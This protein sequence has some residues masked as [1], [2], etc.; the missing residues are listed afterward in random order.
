MHCE[1]QL[2]DEMGE[3]FLSAES[4]GIKGEVFGLAELMVY[5]ALEHSSAIT[6]VEL[7]RRLCSQTFKAHLQAFGLYLDPAQVEGLVNDFPTSTLV[8]QELKG[9]KYYF[10]MSRCQALRHWMEK[11]PEEYKSLQAQ[12]HY[13]WFWNLFTCIRNIDVKPSNVNQLSI[14][15]QQNLKSAAWHAMQIGTLPGSAREVL[16]Q[17][18]GLTDEQRRQRTYE[19]IASFLTAAAIYR[20][21]GNLKEGY[22]LIL[23]AVD[24]L[25]DA[26]DPWREEWLECMADQS[27][28][29]YWLSG[30]TGVREQQG[31]LIA[32]FP[33]LTSKP[34]WQIHQRFEEMLHGHE[35]LS[36][37]P[38]DPCLYGPYLCN[39]HRLTETLWDIRQR[40]GVIA[41]AL[42]DNAVHIHEAVV[43]LGASAFLN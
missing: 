30:D 38:A 11:H 37:C 16:E 5:Q 31:N 43:D 14:T 1:E 2:I 22:Y 35:V 3:N 32:K 42:R 36:P 28:Q 41:L 18:T 4:K 6:K 19:V 21:E 26:S 39:L 33:V 8:R 29:N 7:Y 12:A 27:W 13:F 10:E 40:H 34:R 17:A 9:Q 15:D 20:N 25:P 23:E 24:W